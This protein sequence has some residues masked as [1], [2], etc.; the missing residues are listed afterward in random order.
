MAR[1]NL[2]AG[3]SEKKSATNSGDEDAFARVSRAPSL[4]YTARG[5][6]GAVTRTIDDL[7]ARADAAEDLKGRIA[8][9]DLVLELDPKLEFGHFRSRRGYRPKISATNAA[10]SVCC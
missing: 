6:F 4:V 3:I 1:K 5:A 7:A 10:G 9:G 8:A 2:L